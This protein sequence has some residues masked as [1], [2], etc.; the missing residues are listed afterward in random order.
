MRPRL[1]FGPRVRGG[2]AV[3][4]VP[5][6]LYL[7]PLPTL[8]RWIR[9]R[10]PGKPDPRIEDA[11]L[12]RWV[13]LALHRLPPPW[14]HTCLKRA[15]VLYYLLRRYGHPAE[16]KIGVKRNSENQVAAHA[17]LVREGSLYLEPGGAD[18]GAMDSYEI[19][20]EFP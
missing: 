13:D 6:L 8:T 2:V 19:M 7:V 18:R 5:L 14:R 15:V 10:K 20:A 4:G 17:W 1:L 12:A 16:L 9:R 3:L 11:W